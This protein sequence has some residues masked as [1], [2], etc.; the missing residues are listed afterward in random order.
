MKK[1]SITTTFELEVNEICELF[2]M[3]NK[4]CIKIIEIL[5]SL[6]YKNPISYNK[7]GYIVVK[8][9][10]VKLFPIHKNNRKN[11]SY[12]KISKRQIKY[13]KDNCELIIKPI[14]L[15]KL[16]TYGLENYF[17]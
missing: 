3:N 8:N 14:S 6:R 17:E 16:N 5:I 7:I 2:L 4:N 10:F 12:F 13:N 11:T 9:A 15:L 1:L